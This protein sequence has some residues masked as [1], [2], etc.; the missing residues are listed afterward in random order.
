[1]TKANY[2]CNELGLDTISMA[3]TIACAMEMFERGI[4]T[5]ADTEGLRLEF[6]NADAMVEA[7]RLTGLGKGFGVKLAMG[8][9]RLAGLY[10][11]PELSMTAKKQ[12]MP[13]YDPRAVQGIGLQYATSN[14]GGC[15]VRGYTISPEVLGVPMKV[16]KDTIEGKPALTALFQ[17]LTAAIDATGACLFTSFGLGAPEYAALMTAVTGETYDADGFITAGERIYNMERLFNLRAGVTCKDDT[18]PERLLKE[19]IPTGPSKGAVSRVPEMLP[20]YYNVRGWNEQ[21]VPTDAKLRELA[22]AGLRE[23]ALAR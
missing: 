15:H 1:V 2:I 19:P 8:S 9:W 14:R 20:E 18:L 22:L 17:N 12:E 21:G 4:I 23:P 6:G 5:L 16:D 13:A 3:S 7:V 10:G 11:H